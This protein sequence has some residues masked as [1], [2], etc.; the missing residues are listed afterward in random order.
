[1]VAI[2][3]IN[4]WLML[5]SSLTSQNQAGY[6]RLVRNHRLLGYVFLS[7]Y[8]VMFFYMS[9]RV[10]GATDGLPTPIVI[11]ITLALLLAPLIFLKVV[12][13]RHYKKHS[14]LLLPLG[15]AIF[16]LSFLLVAIGAFPELLATLA[17]G[18]VTVIISICCIATVLTMSGTLFLRPAGRRSQAAPTS[19][20][21]NERIVPSH[22]VGEKN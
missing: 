11:H 18:N 17:I 21:T 5:E 3:G 16:V 12:I 8:T 2:A 20:E 10:L 15:L 19:I 7:L 6:A 13:A 4:V 1:M 9:S 14:S 22:A